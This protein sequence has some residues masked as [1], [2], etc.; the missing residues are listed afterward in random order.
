MGK[1]K[2]PE[3]SAQGVTEFKNSKANMKFTTADGV[4]TIRAKILNFYKGNDLNAEITLSDEPEDTMVIA[5]PFP[6]DKGVLL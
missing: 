4:R 3:T 5:T 1:L 6:G 2:L